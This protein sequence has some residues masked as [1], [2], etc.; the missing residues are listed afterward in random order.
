MADVVHRDGEGAT[1][2]FV[3]H[4]D[5][6]LF[7]RERERILQLLIEEVTYRAAGDEVVITFWPGDVR[8][9]AAQRNRN[10]A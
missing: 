6:E 7:P 9:L 2:S 3:L 8:A 1:R 10:S 4:Q 5:S